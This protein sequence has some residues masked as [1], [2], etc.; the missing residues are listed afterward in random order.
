MLG[1]IVEH[2]SQSGYDLN[3]AP[4]NHIICSDSGDVSSSL[5]NAPISIRSNFF[6]RTF[7]I[8]SGYRVQIYVA[9]SGSSNILRI[10]ARSS[11]L[12]TA[13]ENKWTNWIEIQTT[14]V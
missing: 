7:A 6:C 4:T 13:G 5:V 14:S 8:G 1:G 10:F 9:F 11:Y 2:I 3:N 12:V